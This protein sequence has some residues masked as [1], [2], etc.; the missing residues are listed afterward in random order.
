ME[1]GCNTVSE[2]RRGAP[3]EK[4]ELVEESAL[5]VGHLVV[6]HCTDTDS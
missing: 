4:D 5:A 6:V 2:K 1:E 3:A